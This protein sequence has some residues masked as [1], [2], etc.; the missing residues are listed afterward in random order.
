MNMTYVYSNVT[1]IKCYSFD[2]H[3]SGHKSVAPS[4]MGA[5]KIIAILNMPHRGKNQ[6]IPGKNPKP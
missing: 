4:N 1:S 5:R 3:S 2:P 6:K